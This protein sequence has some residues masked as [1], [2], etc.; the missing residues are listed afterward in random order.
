MDI[1]FKYEI[2]DE[3]RVNNLDCRGTILAYFMEKPF[4]YQ[5]GTLWMEKDLFRFYQKLILWIKILDLDLQQ[6]DNKKYKIS[7]IVE[8]ER[9]AF[10][11]RKIINALKIIMKQSMGIKSS[12]L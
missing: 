9:P 5:L 8:Y 2:G 10:L 6:V 12:G 3:V 1:N 7:F 4:R 11:V